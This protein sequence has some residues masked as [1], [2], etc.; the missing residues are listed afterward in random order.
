MDILWTFCKGGPKGMIYV[1][2]SKDGKGVVV[3]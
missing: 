1:Y 3:N 2:F